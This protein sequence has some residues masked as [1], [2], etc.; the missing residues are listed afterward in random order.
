MY[1]DPG[2]LDA[3]Q[4][5]RFNGGPTDDN[6]LNLAAAALLAPAPPRLA[7][8]D[9]ENTPARLA[10]GVSRDP[11]VQHGPFG[12]ASIESIKVTMWAYRLP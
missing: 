3:T 12:Y 7:S 4:G 8:G 11:D 6:T 1:P 2:L 9:G 5:V 10:I